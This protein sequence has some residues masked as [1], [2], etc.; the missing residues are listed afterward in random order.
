MG[1]AKVKHMDL[2]ILNIYA[3]VHACVGPCVCA[4][5]CA[6]MCAHLHMEKDGVRYYPW[7]VST[8]RLESE[9]VTNPVTCQLD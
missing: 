2:N 4:C 1:Y 8:F 5:M 9:S 6:H 7:S 3:C